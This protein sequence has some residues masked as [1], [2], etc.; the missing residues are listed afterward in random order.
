MSKVLK[1]LEVAEKIGIK[2]VFNKEISKGTWT[3]GKVIEI[4]PDTA[5]EYVV[6]HEVGHAI[7]GYGCCREH[8]EYVAHGIAIGLA[9][10]F[11]I[12]IPRKELALIDGYAGRSKHI[13]CG[14]ITDCSD[15]KFKSRRKKKLVKKK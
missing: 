15:V 7:F 10:V 3:K 6:L 4:N 1:S 5:T 2:I 11:N 13:A 9:K 14:A 12:R 8:C